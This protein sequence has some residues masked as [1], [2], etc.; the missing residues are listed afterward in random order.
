M[1]LI[2]LQ[3]FF[4]PENKLMHPALPIECDLIWVQAAFDCSPLIKQATR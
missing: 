4:A 2:Y 1:I 3:C